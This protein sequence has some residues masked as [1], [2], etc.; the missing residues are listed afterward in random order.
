MKQREESPIEQF[1]SIDR[2]KSE[3]RQGGEKEGRQA[4]GQKHEGLI[5]DKK[6]CPA[7]EGPSSISLSAKKKQNHPA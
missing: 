4:G 1:G 3:R 6:S 2:K 7:L 5:N